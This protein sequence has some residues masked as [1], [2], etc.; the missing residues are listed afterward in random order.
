[1][2]RAMTV[3][4]PNSARDFAAL[5]IGV[6][7][8]RVGMAAGDL[9]RLRLELQRGSPEGAQAN[10]ADLCATCEELE[11][12]GWLFGMLARE[13]GCDVLFARRE[14]SGLKSSLWLVSQVLAR[15][16]IEL[17][18]PN[19]PALD[20]KD[21]SG[22]TLCAVVA[23]CV[24]AAFVDDPNTRWNVEKSASESALCFEGEPGAGLESALREGTLRLSG[25]W[26]CRENGSVR[27]CLPAGSTIWS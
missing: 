8:D 12:L 17:C 2:K 26:L 22:A 7:L 20:P 23:R 21:E 24:H 25:S 19:L 14:R 15:E 9:T 18:L 10:A 1:M 13:L 6:L 16:G 3:R 27:F 4:A 5:A 11:R